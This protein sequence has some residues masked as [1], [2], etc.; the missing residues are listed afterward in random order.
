MSI[1]K[2]IEKLEN[3]RLARYPMVAV[4]NEDCS[5]H[6]NDQLYPDEKAFKKALRDC[7]YTGK[8]LVLDI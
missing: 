6:W 8:L 7:E 2:R 4:L 3:H 5:Y 1:K